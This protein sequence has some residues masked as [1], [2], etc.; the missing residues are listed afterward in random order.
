[1]KEKRTLKKTLAA[2]LC[3]L[4]LLTVLPFAALAEETEPCATHSFEAVETV[5]PTCSA[6]GYTLY[7][8][9][10]CG[11]TKQDDIVKTKGHFDGN[12]DDLCD[13]CGAIMPDAACKY[14]GKLHNK[15]GERIIAVIHSAL[16]WFLELSNFFPFFDF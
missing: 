1:M 3:A 13:D 4:M 6:D 7:R 9:T 2:L 15:K 10:N 12:A 11:E 14:C 5:A 16:Y 8:C